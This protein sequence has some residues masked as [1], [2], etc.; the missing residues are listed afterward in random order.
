MHTEMWR[1]RVRISVAR[2]WLLKCLVWIGLAGFNKI[3][4]PSLTHTHGFPRGFSRCNLP[5]PG[6]CQIPTCRAKALSYGTERLHQCILDVDHS[7]SWAGM[8]CRLQLSHENQTWQRTNH[9][10]YPLKG[11]FTQKR[12]GIAGHPS[13]RILLSTFRS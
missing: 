11:W 13:M 12:P 9:H 8:L 3:V 2:S 10:V 5:V 4:T 1:C 6:R 7:T